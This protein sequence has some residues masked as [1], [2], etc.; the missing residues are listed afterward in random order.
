MADFDLG[1]ELQLNEQARL[2]EF[3]R[4]SIEA[5]LHKVALPVFSSDSARLQVKCGTFVTLTKCR[6]LRGCIGGVKAVKPM[7][8]AVQ[9]A[10]LSAA[11]EDP[12]FPP[13]ELSELP[14]VVIEVSVITLLQTIESI[15]QI[16]VREHGLFVKLGKTHAVLLPQVAVRNDWSRDTFLEQVCLK[17]GLT[18]S[19]WHDPD[20]KIMTFEAQVFRETG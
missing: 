10:A 4:N 16:K 9:A 18:G 15:L 11:F 14:A 19:A 17:A 6:N 1:Y 20:M 3:A 7:C 2:L 8:L 12:R 5:K 13:L